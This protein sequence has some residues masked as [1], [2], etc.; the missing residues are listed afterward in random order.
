VRAD[1]A[2]LDEP[3]AEAVAGWLQTA[4]PFA[5]VRYLGRPGLSR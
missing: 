5:Q 4:W 3:L 1:R 2:E